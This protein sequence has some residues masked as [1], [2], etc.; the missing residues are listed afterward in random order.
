MP[1]DR[2]HAGRLGNRL[3]RALDG[4]AF[5]R[6]VHMDVAFPAPAVGR[7]FMAVGDGFLG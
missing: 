5:R 3:D 2:G 7:H 1:A 6:L 4:A